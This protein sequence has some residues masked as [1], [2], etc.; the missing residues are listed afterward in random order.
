MTIHDIGERDFLASIASMVRQV[1]GAR[2]EFD[3]DAS[4]IPLTDGTHMVVKVDT[5][6]SGS[7][8][9]PGMTETQ[10]GRKTAVMV[11]SDLAAKGATP[12]AS[13]LSLCAPKDSEGSAIRD[14]I[15]GY[16]QYCLK[17]GMSFIGGD[18]GVSCET[19][20]TGV[21]LGTALRERIVPRGGTRQGDIIAATGPFGLTS[22]AFKILLDGMDAPSPLRQRALT[23]A[24]KPE[25]NLTL[26]PMLAEERAITASMDSSD[27]LGITLNTMANHSHLAF[28]VDQL[29]VAQGVAEFAEANGID[30][31]DLI[32]RGGEEFCLVLTVPS[33]KWD[34]A[35]SISR[36]SHAELIPIGHA[37]EGKGVTWQSPRGP[38]TI[39]MAGYDDFR[40]WG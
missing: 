13:M 9:L 16:S 6:N 5:F 10:V 34:E 31:L 18:M 2:L 3:D 14:M 20:L 15:R 37:R 1:P 11:I 27:G 35:L 12:I 22:V 36:Q 28:S 30:L 29:P 7:D 19:V 26:V 32:M 4:D 39:P 24:Y 8:W 21:A 23:A 25:I 40:E 33:D 17:N 38:V